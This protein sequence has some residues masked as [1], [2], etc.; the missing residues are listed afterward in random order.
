MSISD[1]KQGWNTTPSYYPR[2][3]VMPS[4]RGGAAL[5]SAPY[6]TPATAEVSKRSA[7]LD[8][9]VE[10]LIDRPAPHPRPTPEPMT[11]TPA[12]RP[13]PRLESFVERIIE[14]AA[15]QALGIEPEVVVSKSFRLGSTAES[16]GTPVIRRKI[17]QL[18]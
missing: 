10:R 14:L 11:E 8:E 1:K 4:F 12:P 6:K 17:V 18:D 7:A 15:D 9:K 3:V 13:R 16:V 2:R 5:F